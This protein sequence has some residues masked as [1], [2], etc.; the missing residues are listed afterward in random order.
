MHK[1]SGHFFKPFHFF[2][3]RAIF[4]VQGLIITN[5]GFFGIKSGF[6]VSAYYKNASTALRIF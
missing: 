5:E 4:E 2:G 1:H 6:C 3:M